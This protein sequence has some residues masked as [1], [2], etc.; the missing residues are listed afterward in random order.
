MGRC[1]KEIL[2][3]LDGSNLGD[4]IV[5]EAVRIEVKGT[6]DVRGEEN[7]ANSSGTRSDVE[8]LQKRNDEFSRQIPTSLQVLFDASRRIEN[9]D[10]VDHVVLAS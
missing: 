2:Y 7:E 9:N 3:L 6:A 1:L 8:V 10:E 4:H 5:A